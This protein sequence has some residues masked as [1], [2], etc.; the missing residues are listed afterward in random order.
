MKK[1]LFKPLAVLSLGAIV[2]MQIHLVPANASWYAQRI[3]QLRNQQASSDTPTKGINPSKQPGNA[4]APPTNSG[5]APAPQPSAAIS[6][7]QQLMVDL[8]N[9]ERA[10]AGLKPLK[11]HEGLMEIAQKKSQDMKDNNY[12]SHTSPTHGSFTKMVSNAGISYR[13]IGENLA[14][15]RDVQTAHKLL[16]ASQPH[17]DNILRS[18]YTHVGIGVA[19]TKYGVIVTQL[20]IMQ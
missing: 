7:E 18:Y 19:H 5:S 4:P 11:I 15:A 14:Q 16:M 8:I 9:K 10:K 1:C 20:F 3:L 2:F 6:G 17:K 12:F 13:A